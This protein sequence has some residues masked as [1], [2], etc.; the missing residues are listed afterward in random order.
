[1]EPREIEQAL[2][3]AR[4]RHLSEATLISYRDNRLDEIGREMADAHLNLCL[5]CEKELDFLKAEQEGLEN[6]ELTGGDRKLIQ[7][8]LDRS[9]AEQQ[10]PAVPEPSAVSRERL[11][12]GLNELTAAWVAHFGRGSVGGGDEE[13]F[14]FE[15]EVLTVS[16]EM[17]RDSSLTVQFSSTYLFL[18]GEKIRFQLGRFTEDLTLIRE[19]DIEVNA[20]VEIPQEQRASKMRDFSVRI[21]DVDS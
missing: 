18:E 1:M 3:N 11:A 12:A 7:R 15:S 14:R 5:L 17:G 4:F 2:K 20:R 8:V 19:G 16:G 6:Y 13:R 21:V 9:E 10:A